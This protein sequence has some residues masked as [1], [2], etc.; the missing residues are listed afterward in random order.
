MEKAEELSKLCRICFDDNDGKPLVPI[1]RLNNYSIAPAEVYTLLGLESDVK[2]FSSSI[3]EECF[4]HI[5]SFDG[6]R[7]RCRK[8]QLGIVKELNYI[9][10]QLKKVRCSDSLN[11]WN[12]LSTTL[13]DDDTDANDDDDRDNDEIFAAEEDEAVEPDVM[14]ISL[15]RETGFQE[16]TVKT[17]SVDDDGS[18]IFESYHMEMNDFDSD[19][20][21]PLVE[22]KTEEIEVEEP[23]LKTRS[24][25]KSAKLLDSEA[26]KSKSSKKISKKSSSIAR[27]EEPMSTKRNSS[28]TKTNQVNESNKRKSSKT[29]DAELDDVARDEDEAEPE[30]EPTSVKEQHNIIQIGD[31][32]VVINNLQSHASRIFECFFCRLVSFYF[33]SAAAQHFLYSNIILE[34]RR[35]SHVQG[36]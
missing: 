30:N 5:V 17:E 28:K 11:S 12:D 9:D 34:I 3:C 24:R 1:N 2:V 8:A 14:N 6:F 29:I 15:D 23:E 33:D 19:D 26:G 13:G 20:E 36:P 22:L 25:K 27:P 32:S 7:K 21:T 18:I 35:S 10:E 16:V 4:Q 31:S